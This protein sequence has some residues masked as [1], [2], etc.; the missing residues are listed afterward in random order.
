MHGSEGICV[1][2]RE[3]ALGAAFLPP[4]IPEIRWLGVRVLLFSE[5]STGPGPLFEGRGSGGTE[6][7]F[8]S[9]CH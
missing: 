5:P 8:P 9:S 3:L 2:G 4:W 6:F 1:E 7:K